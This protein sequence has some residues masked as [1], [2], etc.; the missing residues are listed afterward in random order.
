MGSIMNK[1]KKVVVLGFLLSNMMYSVVHADD[2][3]D[4]IIGNIA[5]LLTAGT[6][7]VA[8]TMYANYAAKKADKKKAATPE[9]KSNMNISDC[10]TPAAAQSRPS[11]FNESY[12]TSKSEEDESSSNYLNNI[13]SV[14]S[15]IRKTAELKNEKN[16]HDRTIDL[17]R[18][19]E[20]AYVACGYFPKA[21]R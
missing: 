16:R 2:A 13:P 3:K 12:E 11:D 15:S 9:L 8:G 19:D 5:V 1:I 7:V 21:R 17:V 18:E 10:K 6:I 4:K 14:D 20:L